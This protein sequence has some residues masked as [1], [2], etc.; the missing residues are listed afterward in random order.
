MPRGP[1]MSGQI[2]NSI[3]SDLWLAQ[4]GW[5][6]CSPHCPML[7]VR[8]YTGIYFMLHLRANTLRLAQWPWNSVTSGALLK[9]ILTMME[10]LCNASSSPVTGSHS[11][12][13]HWR[14]P[15]NILSWDVLSCTI[16]FSYF[17]RGVKFHLSVVF[18]KRDNTRHEWLTPSWTLE[19][20][21]DT[22]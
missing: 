18:F 11:T 5:T 2:P 21:G 17:L 16:L 12:H 4:P 20:R 14:H 10:S 3:C 9:V 15:V 6:M 1:T 8:Y 7:T 22:H 19:V 13:K